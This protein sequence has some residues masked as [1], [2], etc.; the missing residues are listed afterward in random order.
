M[1]LIGAIIAKVDNVGPVDILKKNDLTLHILEMIDSFYEK[2]CNLVNHTELTYCICGCANTDNFFSLV[3]LPNGHFIDILKHCVKSGYIL[4]DMTFKK[5]LAKIIMLNKINN[6]DDINVFCYI[7]KNIF[8]SDFANKYRFNYDN[9]KDYDEHMEEKKEEKKNNKSINILTKHNFYSLFHPLFIQTLFIQNIQKMKKYMPKFFY[10]FDGL[11]FD[12]TTPLCENSLLSE[13]IK[14]GDLYST[15]ELFKRG[16]T[17]DESCYQSLHDLL[18]RQLGGLKNEAD[19]IKT[20][21]EWQD[22]TWSHLDLMLYKTLYDDNIAL[23]HFFQEKYINEK[24]DDDDFAIEIK[25]YVDYNFLHIREEDRY[26]I[27]KEICKNEK[28]KSLVCNPQKM[29][30][31]YSIVKLCA[32]NNLDKKHEC[33]SEQSLYEDKPHLLHPTLLNAYMYGSKPIKI[34]FPDWHKKFV[35]LLTCH[36]QYSD[37]GV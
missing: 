14:A 22:N 13:A 7:I 5:K 30:D 31:I 28:R 37:F 16:C 21:I 36:E 3:N 11:S 18:R 8:G 29:S 32:S 24:S 26:Y 25:K 4:N 34:I 9:N 23:K 17:I 27:Y 20:P 33:F 19:N 35:E 10:I 15:S 12:Y 6:E 1:E 2:K